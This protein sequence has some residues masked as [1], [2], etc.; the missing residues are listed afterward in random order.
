LSQ[1]G[2]IGT[3]VLVGSELRVAFEVDVDS[4]ASFHA[5]AWILVSLAKL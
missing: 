4:H 3:G 1:G 2:G 5:A